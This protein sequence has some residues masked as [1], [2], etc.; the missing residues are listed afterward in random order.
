M[1]CHVKCCK[2][3]NIF[4]LTSF[5]D[6]VTADFLFYWSFSNGKIISVVFSMSVRVSNNWN[7]ITM[8]W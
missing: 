1:F 3:D 8:V 2:V 7:W 6:E 5:I 4:W